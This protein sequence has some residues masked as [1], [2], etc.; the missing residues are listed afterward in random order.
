[1]VE[2]STR[3]T[4]ADVLTH[5]F[6]EKKPKKEVKSTP[7]SALMKELEEAFSL[8]F[9]GAYKRKEDKAAPGVVVFNPSKEMVMEKGSFVKDAHSNNE[10]EYGALNF[11][12]EWCLS[13]GITRL[14]VYGDSML[15]VKQ[16]QGTWA[17]KSDKLA[18]KLHAIKR[19]LRKFK[20]VHV[21]YI[22]RGKNQLAD[23]L[24]S[25]GLK[26]AIMVP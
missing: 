24:A 8:Y 6:H 2:D 15:I 4:L 22:A 1:M 14:N 9:D 7:P 20:A 12:L 25:D 26:E 23:A 21:H 10:A 11:G 13:N 3:A 17:C 5:R 16:I 19:V 18:T